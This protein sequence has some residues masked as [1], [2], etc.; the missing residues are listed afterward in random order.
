M[1]NSVQTQSSATRQSDV[2]RSRVYRR[3][4]C[5][6]TVLL[7]ICRLSCVDSED[8]EELKQY[9]DYVARYRKKMRE[10]WDFQ[11]CVLVFGEQYTH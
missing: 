2:L 8:K 4:D 7:E 1:K 3:Y 6:G 11:W 10:H 5:L 9:W